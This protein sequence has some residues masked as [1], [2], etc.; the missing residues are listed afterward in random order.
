MLRLHQI[1]DGQEFRILR[2]AP[3]AAGL[4]DIDE[5]GG[6]PLSVWQFFQARNRVNPECQPDDNG[7]WPIPCMMGATNPIEVVSGLT[8]GERIVT[9]ANFLVDSESK[10][11]AS[12][13]QMRTEP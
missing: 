7:A 13:A 11:R 5:C 4:E 9:R 8:A 2:R 6:I 3:R 10:L 12:L 1:E